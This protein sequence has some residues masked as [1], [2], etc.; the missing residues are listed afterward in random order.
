MKISD[1]QRLPLLNTITTEN[2]VFETQFNN[3]CI[4]CASHTPFFRY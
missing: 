4:L 3:V 1:A 2:F